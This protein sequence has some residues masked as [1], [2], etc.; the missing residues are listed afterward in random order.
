MSFKSTF[1][2]DRAFYKK[3]AAVAI[4]SMFQQLLS[5]MINLVDNLI[6]AS[7][8]DTAL[9]GVTAANRVYSI[10]MFAIMA[11]CQTAVVFFA[12]YHGAKDLKHTK[13]TIRIGLIISVIAILPFFLAAYLFP[14]Q[15]ISLLTK[16]PQ[17]IEMGVQY[18]RVACW[19]Y[20]I[21]PF[22]MIIANVLRAV[23]DAK[24][25]L[26]ISTFAILLNA[27]FSFTLIYGYFGFP[28]IGVAGAA[29]GTLIAQL[30]FLTILILVLVHRKYDF[31]PKATSF[32]KLNFKLTI[33]I[34]KKALP[35]TLNEIGW[36]AGMTTLFALYS[37]KGLE[38]MTAYSMS[39]TISD[40]V[41]VL[42]NGMGV[43]TTVMVARHLGANELDVA[44]SNAYKLLFLSTVTAIVMGMCLFFAAPYLTLLYTHVGQSERDIANYILRI[45]GCMFFIYTFSTQIYFT[46]RAGGDMRS[47][48]FMDSVFMWTVNI[49]FMY[50]LIHYSG[51]SIFG[52]YFLGQCTDLIKLFIGFYVFKREKWVHNLTTEE[53]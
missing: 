44:K 37:Y 19:T 34:L 25:P 10:A 39:M 27:F 22:T 48:L 42:F 53:V 40:M 32:L 41:F 1:I 26:V 12:Q 33:R 45:Q 15:V 13:D 5:T 24:T 9:S 35:L 50:C 49:P 17:V 38:V 36:S 43:A 30:V 16:D 2:A 3:A 52:I 21:L 6:V 46:L 23:G 14:Y 31:F 8:G 7:I 11:L 51:L 28:A 29:V 20:P 4:P 18:L 47:T